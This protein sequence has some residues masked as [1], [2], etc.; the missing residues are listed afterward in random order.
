MNY[1]NTLIAQDIKNLIPS[2]PSVNLALNKP[3]EQSSYSI[4]SK[5]NDAQG[6]VNGIKTG[7]F[8]FHTNKEFKP[9]WQVDL[10]AVYNIS[11]IRVFNCLTRNRERSR[12]LEVLISLNGRDW[13]SVYLNEPY[14]IFG[15]IDGNLLIVTLPS[16]M[17]MTRYIRLQL[18]QENYLH[19]DEVEVYEKSTPITELIQ[20]LQ[21]KATQVGRQLSRIN[22][23]KKNLNSTI[24]NQKQR[25]LELTLEY[26]LRNLYKQKQI[27]NFDL[28][29]VR[30]IIY[31]AD[32]KNGLCNRLRT[33]SSCLALSDVLE[34]PLVVCWE[35]HDHCDCY[36][37]DLF[38]PT[39]VTS[40]FPTII[41]NFK[42]SFLD[43]IYIV[44]NSRNTRVMYVDYLK[45]LKIISWED[46]Q[47]K[48]FNFV[49]K[50]SLKKNIQKALDDFI[51]N[52]W[53]EDI[54]GVHI[55]RTDHGPYCPNAD[56]LSTDSK[57]FQ[58]IDQEIS[59]GVSKFFLATDN[60]ETQAI[61]KNRYPDLFINYCQEFNDSQLRQTSV[62]AALMDLYL[63][64]R[65][66]KII[67]SNRSSFSIY[68]SELGNIP[69]EFA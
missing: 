59:Q 24:L 43:V 62:Q 7:E 15:G 40:D 29:N 33:L 37:E 11:E 35:P 64:S 65:T 55:R 12:T 23:R 48:Y 57:F 14:Y 67:G 45:K 3:A 22:N 56:I 41:S 27:A 6:A 69:V 34:I 63:L 36:F 52:N 2:P 4:W 10:E 17:T 19:L 13:Q 42:N 50:F 31:H 54:V 25:K 21:A 26:L 68:A 9:W 18:R 30:Q 1:S 28:K 5:P 44:N 20:L 32:N 47:E 16:K 46:Y 58:K 53:T 60:A 39:L 49:R 8:G 66:K 38:E 61:F 51:D